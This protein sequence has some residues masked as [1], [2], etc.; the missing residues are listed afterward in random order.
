MFISHELDTEI[1][2]QVHDFTT[3]HGEAGLCACAVCTKYCA[4]TCWQVTLECNQLV[5]WEMDVVNTVNT[6]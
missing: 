6:T 3:L 2:S 1:S 5:N 4:R